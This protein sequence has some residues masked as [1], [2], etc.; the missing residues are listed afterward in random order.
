MKTLLKLSIG[1]AIA[2]AIQHGITWWNAKNAEDREIRVMVNAQFDVCEEIVRESGVSPNDYGNFTVK[3]KACA[4]QFGITVRKL[5][6]GYLERIIKGWPEGPEKNYIK[7]L[8]EDV[9]SDGLGG[10]VTR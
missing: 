3:E 10:I 1:A 5:P 6:K 2:L 8:I 9:D 7:D 4:D